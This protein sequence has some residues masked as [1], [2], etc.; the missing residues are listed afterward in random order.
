MASAKQGLSTGT[1]DGGKPTSQQEKLSRDAQAVFRGFLIL[2]LVGLVFVSIN[3]WGSAASTAILWALACLAIGSLVGFLFGIPRVLQG[4]PSQNPSPS[5]DQQ[6]EK[7]T[8]T[9]KV[10]T[11]LEQISD[12]LTKIFVGLGLVQ[13]QRVPDHLRRASEFVAWGLAPDSKFF[14]GGLILYFSVLGFLGFYL[15]TRLYISGAFARADKDASGGD[16]DAKIVQAAPSQASGDSKVSEEQKLAARRLVSR[17]LDQPSSPSDAAA[18]A[19]AQLSLGEYAQAVDAYSK[20]VA[21]SPDDIMLRL[22]YAGALFHK[23]DRPS[24]KNQLL[25]AHKRITSNTSRDE[26]ERVYAAL[27]FQSLYEAPPIGFEESI[28]YGEEY[29]RDA[30]NPQSGRIWLNLASAYGQ[31]MAWIIQNDPDN[32]QS[33]ADTRSKAL[34]AARRAVAFG[35]ELKEKLLELLQHDYPN[36]DPRENDL[37]VFEKDNAFRELLGLPPVNG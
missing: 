8:Y 23:G 7:S 19:K 22:E 34:N 17:S 33:K 30:Q 21:E 37:E 18:L 15:L 36:K 24:A 14:A 32:E 35:A 5:N 25:E 9:L 16:S 6:G 12:W 29:V 20:L 31:R 10:N 28:K 4:E 27:T 26:K 2:S 1:G 13:L 11:N 3:Q